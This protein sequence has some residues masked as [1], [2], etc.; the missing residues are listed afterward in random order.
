MNCDFSI[1][2][3]DWKQELFKDEIDFTRHRGKSLLAKFNKN[4]G[5]L[6]DRNG[7]ESKYFKIYCFFFINNTALNSYLK[8]P[9]CFQL[10]RVSVGGNRPVGCGRDTVATNYFLYP[11][12]KTCQV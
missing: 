10:K 9:H 1:G 5:P 8:K 6:N 3:C 7:D 11:Y 4:S 2:L 12:T